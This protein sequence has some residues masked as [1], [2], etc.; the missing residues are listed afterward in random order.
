MGKQQNS[1][2]TLRTHKTVKPVPAQPSAHAGY[3]FS[4]R[5]TLQLTGPSRL[6]EKFAPVREG[7]VEAMLKDTSAQ[8][9]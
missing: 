4:L 1:L 7:F 5:Y 3:P 9:F 8:H 6:F 2:P